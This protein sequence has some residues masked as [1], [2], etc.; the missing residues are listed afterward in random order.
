MIEIKPPVYPQLENTPIFLAGG[1]TDCPDWQSEV[2]EQLVKTN[3]MIFNPRRDY[4]DVEDSRMTFEQIRWEFAHL[5]LAKGVVF[6]F[7][8]ETLCPITLFELGS[9]LEA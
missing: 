4:F 3:L 1:I 9:R 5:R 8:K 2:V 6:W 7:P